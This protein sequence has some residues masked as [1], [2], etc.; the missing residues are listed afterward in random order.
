MTGSAWLTL[1][2]PDDALGLVDHLAALHAGE[3]PRLETPLLA[4][5]VVG[6]VAVRAAEST[7]PAGTRARS[8][9][10]GFHTGADRLQVP[11]RYRT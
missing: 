4:V 2:R 10:T 6:L 11:E 7:E 1:E 3:R 8:D 9:R 5:A